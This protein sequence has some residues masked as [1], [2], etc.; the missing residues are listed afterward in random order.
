M[1]GWNLIFR[2]THLYLGMLL[3]PWMLIYSISTVLFNHGSW[4]RESHPAD[5]QWLPLW[6]REYTLKTPLQEDNLREAAMRMLADNGLEGPYSVQ[7]QGER[8][9]VNM[10]NFREPRRVTYDAGRQRILAEKRK[11]A[12]SELLMRLHFR[13]GYGQPGFLPGLWAAVVDLFC[14]TL[15]VW[16]ATGLYLW[17]KIPKSRAWGFATIGVGFATIVMLLLTL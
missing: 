4:F 16:I 17:W 1:K 3:I 12:W 5:P 6:D 8:V 9:I 10:P 2:R 7:R 13:V 14:V 11:F 15:L